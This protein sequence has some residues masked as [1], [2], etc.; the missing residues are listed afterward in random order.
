MNIASI[1]QHILELRAKAE[2][3][4]PQHAAWDEIA[5]LTEL[6]QAKA[7]LDEARKAYRQRLQANTQLTRLAKYAKLT[8]AMRAD[9]GHWL[10]QH[11]DAQATLDRIL[12]YGVA[13]G[14]VSG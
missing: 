10:K 8:P 3:V 2:P 5:E 11:A 9:R 14:Q 12:G 13:V 7:L 6:V 4:G 1:K